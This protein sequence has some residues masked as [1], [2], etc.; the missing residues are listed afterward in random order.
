MRDLLRAGFRALGFDIFRYPKG[1]EQLEAHLRLLVPRRGVDVLFDVG[2]NR[3]QFAAQLRRIH[4][5]LQIHSFE[6]HP[7][8]CAALRGCAANHPSWHVYAFG[9]GRS[10]GRAE[11]TC[12]ATDTFSSVLPI[13]AL[14]RQRF[15]TELRPIDSVEIALR[16]LAD[17]IENDLRGVCGNR[18]MLKL[19]TQ[20]LDFDVLQGA[21]SW[22]D[23]FDL[24]V[25]EA[26][27]RPIYERAARFGDI[28][29]FLTARGFTLS[30]FF[31]VSRADDFS[32]IEADVVFVRQYSVAD[33]GQLGT[34]DTHPGS[35]PG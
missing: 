15:S 10:A 28:L 34:D 18:P 20:G 31:P 3:G 8:A 16:T 5:A 7:A 6:P 33:S 30:G 32:V 11:L 26:S 14:G 24:V 25:T 2:A 4:P 23:R 29:E 12:Y 27:L 19:D 35:S 21:G 9:L 17:V 22:L 13:N 1:C